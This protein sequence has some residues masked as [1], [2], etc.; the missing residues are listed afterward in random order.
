M[1]VGEY[2][3]YVVQKVIQ[4]APPKQIWRGANA[5][6]IWFIDTF[7]LQWMYGVMFR[8]QYGLDTLKPSVY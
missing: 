5:S 4:N 8:K 7:G 1:P 3:Q 6:M 2:S